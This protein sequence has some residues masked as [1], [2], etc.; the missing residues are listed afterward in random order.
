MGLMVPGGWLAC[1]ALFASLRLNASSCSSQQP[2]SPPHPLAP[3]QELDEEALLD[4]AHAPPQGSRRASR[5]SARNLGAHPGADAGAPRAGPAQSVASPPHSSGGGAAATSAAGAPPPVPGSSR[6]ASR[7]ASARGGAGE[8]LAAAAAAAGDAPPPGAPLHVP[9]PASRRASRTLSG[10]LPPDQEPP[11]PAVMAALDEADQDVPPRAPTALGVLPSRRA[12][13]AATASGRG[14]PDSDGFGYSGFEEDLLPEAAA[15]A[16]AA[17]GPAPPPAAGAGDDGPGGGEGGA[18]QASAGLATLGGKP[19]GTGGGGRSVSGLLQAAAAAAAAAE[20]FIGGYLSGRTSRAS[21][22]GDSGGGAPPVPGD[23]LGE[24]V[25]G[26]GAGGA[27]TGLLAARHGIADSFAVEPVDSFS[28]P[29]PVFGG[30][31]A[32][33][34][35]PAKGS[36]TFPSPL[37]GVAG[38]GGG[39]PSPLAGR[40]P[41]LIAAFHAAAASPPPQLPGPRLQLP[42]LESKLA[43]G[44][45]VRFK[46][47]PFFDA[48]MALQDSVEGPLIGTQ[49][50]AGGGSGGGSAGAQGE[51]AAARRSAFGGVSIHEIQPAGD[52]S[53][54][55]GA[56]DRSAGSVS[57]AA[58]PGGAGRSASGSSGAGSSASGG[59]AA[60]AVRSGAALPGA[61]L[62]GLIRRSVSGRAPASGGSASPQAAPE[63]RLLPVVAAGDDGLGGHLEGATLVGLPAMS[64]VDYETVPLV[65]AASGA[66]CAAAAAAQVGVG[67]SP[68]AG[69]WG[70]A[71][72]RATGLVSSLPGALTL[73]ALAH[74]SGGR[75]AR[76]ARPGGPRRPPRRR[77]QRGAVVRRRGLWPRRA[78]ARRRAHA[79]G[80]GPRGAAAGGIRAVCG[81]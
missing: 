67:P 41:T 78:A 76:R 32:S 81:R 11:P 66:A 42:G 10:R 57:S 59:G 12:S 27:G 9:G 29:P 58:A 43:A 77:R 13:A 4:A 61:E 23:G 21:S 6:R 48:G 74:P 65:G 63:E 20:T 16:P 17:V 68:A 45:P 64:F 30:G 80:R 71:F 46:P 52:A 39:A 25:F 62:P 49:V 56:V 2:R 31:S 28:C 14:T 24:P 69:G 50:A 37:K 75:R 18:E 47:N 7:A 55:D 26:A 44:S 40:V 36:L 79:A 33:G 35:S 8:L 19:R 15:A 54:S 70:C 73:A 60:A 34:R 1:A 53:D 72:A 22:S 38:D 51:G 5:T 3:P